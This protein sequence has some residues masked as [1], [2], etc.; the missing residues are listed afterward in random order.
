MPNKHII[1]RHGNHM[2]SHG[3]SIFVPPLSE[4]G[5]AAHDAIVDVYSY[6]ATLGLTSGRSPYVMMATSIR[7]DAATIAPS[8]RLK[9][10]MFCL[11]PD[12]A[13]ALAANLQAAAKREREVDAVLVQKRGAA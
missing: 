12:D 5:L 8:S 11:S 9:S 6:F 7:G 4:K 1:D 13:E 3:K 10:V 2:E